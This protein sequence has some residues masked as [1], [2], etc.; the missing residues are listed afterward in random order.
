MVLADHLNAKIFKPR[1]SP[2]AHRGLLEVP[3]D[4][5]EMQLV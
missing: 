3:T 5:N 1:L 2:T 4:S